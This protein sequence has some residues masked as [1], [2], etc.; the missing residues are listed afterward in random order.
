MQ[1]T[2]AYLALPAA[3]PGNRCWPQFAPRML[4]RVILCTLARHLA[5]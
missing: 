2:A 5:L 1:G 3:L 4:S